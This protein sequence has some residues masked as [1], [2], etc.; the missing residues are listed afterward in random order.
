MKQQLIADITREMLPV[1]NNYQLQQLQKVL[2][3]CFS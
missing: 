2:N 1:L 3:H